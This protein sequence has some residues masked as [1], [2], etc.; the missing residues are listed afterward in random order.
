MQ[1]SQ[2]RTTFGFT[3]IELLIVIAIIAILALIAVPNFLEAQTRAKVSRVHADM[4]TIAV[5]IEAYAV[6]WG[7]A[8]IGSNEGSSSLYNLWHTDDRD[9][10]YNPMTT[11][12]AYLTSIP[13]DPFTDKSEIKRFDTGLIRNFK[14][15][16][17][18]YWLY[19]GHPGG[20]DAWL[21]MGYT[22]YLR[23]PG[24][25]RLVGPPFMSVMTRDNRS[26]NIYDSTNGTMSIGQIY[27][28]NKGV[29]TVPR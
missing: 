7:R 10:A 28:T 16:Q 6:D 25:S 20:Y 12:V 5:A 14:K 3:L 26:D 23:S 4:R 11:P 9:F 2:R 22:W 18:Q 15:Y 13:D 17:Y 21:A 1:N 24:P 29:F 19:E 27:R 8:P